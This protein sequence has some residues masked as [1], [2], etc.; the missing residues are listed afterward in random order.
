MIIDKDI[1]L[2]F[3]SVAVTAVVTLISVW[4]GHLLTKSNRKKAALQFEEAIYREVK[5]LSGYI[6][7]T[8]PSLIVDFNRP[9]VK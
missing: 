1:A 3:V 2:V 6:N 8:L 7:K 4:I 9:V 5:I